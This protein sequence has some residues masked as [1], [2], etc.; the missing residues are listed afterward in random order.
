M[1]IRSVVGIACCILTR[2]MHM[3][4]HFD[5]AELLVKTTIVEG[6]C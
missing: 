1:S 3:P 5:A 6:T 4:K 2:L